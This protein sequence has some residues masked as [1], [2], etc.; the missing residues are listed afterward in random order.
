MRVSQGKWNA[1]RG[2]AAIR[3][4]YLDYLL[5]TVLYLKHTE[6]RRTT[7]LI[8][9]LARTCL[10][11]GVALTTGG[12]LALPPY[13]AKELATKHDNKTSKRYG[14]WY[15]SIRNNQP[16]NSRALPKSDFH[17]HFNN[18]STPPLDSRSSAF[19]AL[20]APPET[21]TEPRRF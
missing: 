6:L 20:A 13:P 12:S 17:H 7:Y 21:S 3:L 18:S 15:Y 11:N 5:A 2:N 1:A 9:A 4:R 10:R 16:L 14:K 19:A 8:Y